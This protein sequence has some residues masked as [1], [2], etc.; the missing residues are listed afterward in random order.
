MPAKEAVVG[1]HG[2]RRHPNY[3]SDNFS[4]A[5]TLTHEEKTLGILLP[6]WAH[7]VFQDI[8]KHPKQRLAAVQE[9]IEKQPGGKCPGETIPNGQGHG[10]GGKGVSFFW[11]SG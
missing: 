10:A 9:C 11:L 6:S 2:A 8:P 1:K 5:C 3:D 4:V 7:S